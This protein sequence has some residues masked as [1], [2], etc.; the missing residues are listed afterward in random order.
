MAPTYIKC[1]NYEKDFP[2]EYVAFHPVA[3]IPLYVAGIEFY[4]VIV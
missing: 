2:L 1:V 3:Y 4:T